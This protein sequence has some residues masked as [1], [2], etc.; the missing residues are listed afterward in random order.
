MM[1]C[2]G[3]EEGPVASGYSQQAAEG[4]AAV[5]AASGADESR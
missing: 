3:G 1:H 5:V 4:T 2:S